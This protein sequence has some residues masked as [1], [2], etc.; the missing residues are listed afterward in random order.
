MD[1]DVSCKLVYLRTEGAHNQ[2]I[3]P[4][5]SKL[6]M[7][8]PSIAIV[9]GEIRPGAR[10]L[11]LYTFLVFTAAILGCR[12]SPLLHVEEQLHDA[13]DGKAVSSPR[14]PVLLLGREMNCAE[15]CRPSWRRHRLP[16]CRSVEGACAP[17]SIA[18]LLHVVVQRMPVQ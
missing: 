6:S 17:V 1:P 4:A 10:Q 9:Q 14:V 3:E 7:A 11:T 16:A 15:P 12:K 5:Q 18:E 2:G 8:L 13:L